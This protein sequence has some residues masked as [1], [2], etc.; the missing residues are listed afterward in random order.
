LGFKRIEDIEVWQKGC[1]LAVDLYRLTEL[2]QFSRDWSLRDQIRR[3][4]V[5]I[6]A[7]IAEGYERESDAEFNRFAIIAKGSCGELRTHVYIA[8][9]IGYL[10]E[11]DF[12]NLTEKCIEISLMLKGLSKYLRKS[13]DSK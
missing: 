2:N 4:A 1:Q 6:P 11:D 8:H 3:A 9:Q 12:R 13:K 10:S 5:S 7:N